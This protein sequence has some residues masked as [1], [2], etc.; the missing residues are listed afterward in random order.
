MFDFLSKYVA[1]TLLLTIIF[2]LIAIKIY[3][4]VS[5]K[6]YIYSILLI[7]LF[8]NVAVVKIAAKKNAIIGFF[9]DRSE[10]LKGLLCKKK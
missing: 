5:V 3:P 6:D 7:S 1:P 2:A 4:N 8:I 10:K 9:I